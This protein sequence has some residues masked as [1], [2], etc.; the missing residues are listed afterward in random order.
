MMGPKA[1]LQRLPQ[2]RQL[3][4][5]PSPSQLRQHLRVV[6]ARDQRLQHRPARDPQRVAGHAGQLDPGILQ[7]LVQPLDLAGALGQQRLAV[8]GQV[9]QL[10]DGFGWDERRADQPVLDQLADPHRVGHVGL[11]AG[12]VLEV[13]GVQQPHLEVVLQ[14]VVHRLPIDPGRLHADHG[15]PEAGQ[16]V[17]QQHQP[18]GRGPKR[19]GL[20]SASALVARHP[21]R[22]GDRCL[23]DVQPGAA[24]DQPLHRSS[25]TLDSNGVARRS[26]MIKSLRS[27]LAATVRGAPG[28][29]V[30]LTNGL[31]RTRM[32]RRHPDDRPIF[33]RQGRPQAMNHLPAIEGSA[34]CGPAFPQ[35]VGERQGPSNAF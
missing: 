11:A 24:L 21:H 5:Q 29:R 19:P 34:L 15:N 23:V 9:P 27:V 3:G 33:I 6:G 16:P 4:A 35:V 10:P 30:P 14:Q 28:S 31:A 1:A 22:G 17:A 13:L 8:A 12:D 7:H 20:G 25:S 18:R 2:R 32:S 26:L